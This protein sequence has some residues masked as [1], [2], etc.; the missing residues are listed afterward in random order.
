MKNYFV[1]LFETFTQKYHQENHCLNHSLK[2]IKMLLSDLLT[3]NQ[4]IAG[5]LN[6]VEVEI[7][8]KLADLQAAI[9]DLTEQLGNLELTDEQTASVEAVQA[10]VD[11]LDNLTPDIEPTPEP[12]PTPE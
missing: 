4:S 5:Q 6:K 1:R 12:E 11:A 9:D 2:E 7:V 10:A 3:I 8:S